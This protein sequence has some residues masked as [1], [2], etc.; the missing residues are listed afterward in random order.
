MLP[1]LLLATL[2]LCEFVF[3]FLSSRGRIPSLFFQSRASSHAY[4]DIHTGEVVP[5][6]M[7]RDRGARQQTHSPCLAVVA[8]VAAPLGV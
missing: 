6:F 1:T 8:A 7:C 3:V 2:L 4:G 5:S